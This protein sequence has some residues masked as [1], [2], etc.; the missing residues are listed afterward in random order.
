MVG[1]V[2]EIGLRSTRI[3]TLDSRLI[4]VPNSDISKSNIINYSLPDAKVRF[5]INVGIAYD[6]NVDKAF[7]VL[8]DIATHTEGV[9]VDPAPQVYV[10][11]LGDFSIN[12]MMHVWAKDYKLS[13]EV[14]DHIY[15]E[16]LRRFAEEK[17]DIP[18]PIQSV[19]LNRPQIAMEAVTPPIKR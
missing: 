14:P 6:S 9:L 1:D 7:A 2:V 15:R 16:I 3:R 19:I 17:I 10:K 13:W 12:L 11:D 5:T 18:Y 4:V 8:K